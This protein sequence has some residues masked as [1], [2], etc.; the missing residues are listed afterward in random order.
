[1]GLALSSIP[2]FG[3]EV[4]LGVLSLKALNTAVAGIKQVPN[5]AKAIWPS[6]AENTVDFQ[7]DALTNLFRGPGASLR[8]QLRSNF[9]DTLAAIQGLDQWNTGAFLAFAGQ[10]LNDKATMFLQTIFDSSWS[11]GP[12]LFEK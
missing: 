12:L 1:M 8:S 5:L 11:T 10:E 9:G 6:G 7:I 3:P 4:G 2:V